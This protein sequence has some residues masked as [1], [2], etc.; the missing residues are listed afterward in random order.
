MTRSA[1][2]RPDLRRRGVLPEGTGHRHVAHASRL[3]LSFPGWLAGTVAAGRPGPGRG[4]PRPRPDPGTRRRR[5]VPCGPGTRGTT[6]RPAAGGRRI[7]ME[8]TRHRGATGPWLRPGKP[9]LTR[10]SSRRRKRPRHSTAPRDRITAVSDQAGT[11]LTRRM[12]TLPGRNTSSRP[13]TGPPWRERRSMTTA[14]PGATRAD[15]CR[16]QATEPGYPRA[17]LGFLHSP[18]SGVASYPQ[19]CPAPPADAP[20]AAMIRSEPPEGEL[21]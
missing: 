12:I 14:S 5:S 10:D 2:V 4:G 16:A 9:A 20:G 1:P 11:R 7:Q 18:E 3:C 17:V 13:G 21:R 15:S 8:A 19:Q 6:S